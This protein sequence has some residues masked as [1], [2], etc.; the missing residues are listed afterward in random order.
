[1]P[2]DLEA[3]TEGGD[4]MAME[5]VYDGGPTFDPPPEDPTFVRLEETR[6]ARLKRIVGEGGLRRLAE[7]RV[8]VLGLGGVGSSCVEALARGGVGR[9]LLVDQDIVQPS[10]INR[11]AIAF[12][13][14]VGRPKIE[15][16]AGMVQDIDPD[17]DVLGYKYF[18]D[19]RNI[20]LFMD[21]HVDSLD[22]VIDAIDSI[23]TKLALARYFCD[24]RRAQG[25]DGER[26][27]PVLISSMGGGNKLD[28]L[29]FSFSDL[30]DTVND[31]IARIMRKEGRKMGITELLVLSSSERPFKTSGDPEAARQQRSGLG[32]MSY[33]P[34][35]MGQLLA[36]YVI[37]DILEDELGL[38][39]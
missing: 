13:S 35:I 29:R 39:G 6:T 25:T 9:F 23:S 8:C 2:W 19:A 1:M 14:T 18:L 24:R 11:Q 33:I 20:G 32:T 12:E 22:Y 36:S 27:W 10:N 17:A 31:P 7:S 3:Q 30:Y 15:V 34:P 5:L 28:P 4:A 38:E 16:M 26:R 21:E 37:R